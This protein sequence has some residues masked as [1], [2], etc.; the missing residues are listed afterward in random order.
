V[1]VVRASCQRACVVAVQR[2]RADGVSRRPD[3]R[4]GLPAA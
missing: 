4:R 2:V 3:A 1:F